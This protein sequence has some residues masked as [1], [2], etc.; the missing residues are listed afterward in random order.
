ME[1]GLKVD[2]GGTLHVLSEDLQGSRFLTMVLQI[3]P[4]GFQECAIAARFI[5]QLLESV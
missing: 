3:F 1:E 5:H 4:I 2:T